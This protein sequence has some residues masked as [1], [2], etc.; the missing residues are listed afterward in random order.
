[1]WEKGTDAADAQKSCMQTGAAKKEGLLHQQRRT[2]RGRGRCT[3]KKKP[4]TEIVMHQTRQKGGGRDT[5]SVPSILRLR[6]GKRLKGP[7]MGKNESRKRGFLSISL[8]PSPFDKHPL[9]SLLSNEERRGFL[10]GGEERQM[11][12]LLRFW[13][14][15]YYRRKRQEEKSSFSNSILP[16]PISPRIFPSFERCLPPSLPLSPIPLPRLLHLLPKKTHFLPIMMTFSS[17]SPFP[18]YPAIHNNDLQVGE[19]PMIQTEL[20]LYFKTRGILR[21]STYNYFCCTGMFGESWRG[22][23]G[24]PLQLH[25]RLRW[26]RE[27]KKGVQQ[28]E[29]ERRIGWIMVLLYFLGRLWAVTPRGEAIFYFTA[30]ILW[31]RRVNVWW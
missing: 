7:E 11:E 29:V 22:N 5:E 27:D 2:E 14:E 12:S 18:F 9:L 10:T 16:Y 23:D 17:L 26:W 1:M 13:R 6:E 20:W 15:I 8:P 24:L 19:S 3:E 4:V 30:F 21:T 28:K 25:R 31:V